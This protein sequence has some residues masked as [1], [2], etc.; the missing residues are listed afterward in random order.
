MRHARRFGKSTE[1]RGDD[2]RD[3]FY[4]DAFLQLTLA[5]RQVERREQVWIRRFLENRGK[6]HLDRRMDE[7]LLAGRCDADELD[8]LTARARAELSNAEKRRFVFNVAQL[9]Q[10]S[11]ALGA[12]EYE[13]ILELTG[14]LGLTDTETDAMLRAAYRVNDSFLAIMGLLAVGAILY[15]TRSV[16]VPLVIALFLSMIVD[17][18][19][20]GIARLLRLG[21]P[22]WYTTAAALV[23]LLGALG[24][25]IVA[26]VFASADIVERFP[27]YKRLVEAEIDRS[28]AAQALLT[29]LGV[30]GHALSGQ[31]LPLAELARGAFGSA[32]SLVSDVV[33]VIIFTGFLVAASK[34]F[35]GVAD[36]MKTKVG[37]Y[38]SV[39]SLVCLLT[40]AAV[41]GVCRAFGVD[42]ALL[43][44]LLA[45][46]LG[47]LPVVGSIASSLPPVVLAMVKFESWWPVLLL[48]LSLVAVNV[49]LGQV[50]EPRLMGSRLALEPLGIL[51]GLAFWGLLWGLPG[52][53]L[54]TPLMVLLRILASQFHFS[55]SLERLLATETT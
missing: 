20:A 4:L 33:L 31:Q 21:G 35:T 49:A 40:G 50:L 10:S 12:R 55:R 5:E 3:L 52:M 34:S 51:V 17:R 26:S 25:L 45:F 41:Y 2:W 37:T 15:L 43:F 54:A 44:A 7:I 9:F 48:A 29:A 39:K 53:I 8:R 13:R 16:L 42:F 14:K 18:V 36:E 28:P 23:A 6:P 1:T 46:L 32:F 47:Y 30:N 11:G 22:R 38:I 27:T 24:G 19:G